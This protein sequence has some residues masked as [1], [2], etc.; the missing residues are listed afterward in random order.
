[1]ALLWSI[2]GFSQI[3]GKQY[4][5]GKL[6]KL[7][8]A[9]EYIKDWESAAEYYNLYLDKKSPDYK[10]LYRLAE[11]QRKGGSYSAAQKNYQT[12][13]EK[14]NDKYPLAGL[15]YAEMLAADGNCKDALPIIKKFRKDYRGEKDDRTYLRLA[16][17]T[18]E[19]CENLDTNAVARYQIKPLSEGVNGSHIEG[20]P[21]YLNN[22]TIVYN[23]L[24]TKGKEV[25][26]VEEDEIPKRKFYVA[27][28]NYGVWEHKSEWRQTELYLQYEIANGA[29]NIAGNRF[30]FS[31]CEANSIGKMA[32]DIY[33]MQQEA[34]EWKPAKKLPAI[35]NSPIYTETQVAVGL[36]EKDQETIY[37]VSDRKEGKGGLDIWYTT[38]D[39]DNDSYKS[40]RNCGSKINSVGDE[41]TPFYKPLNRTLFFS[42]NGHPNYGGLDIFKSSGARTKWLEPENIGNEINTAAD[43][44][45]YVESKKGGEGIFASNRLK[46]GSEDK[47]CCDDLYEFKDVNRIQIAV[48]GAMVDKMKTGSDRYMEGVQ[49]RLFKKDQKTGEEVLVQTVKTKK[50]GKYQFQLEQ[51]QFYTL[52]T[53]KVGFLIQ[54]HDIITTGIEKSRRYIKNFALEYYFGRSIVVENIYYEFDKAALTQES[55]ITIDTTIYEILVENPHIIIELSSHTDS[56]GSDDYN[57]NLSQRRAESVVNYL[58]KKGIPKKRLTPKGYGENKPRVPNKNADGSDN[59]EGRAK[60]RRTEFKVIG[61]MDVEVNY[62]E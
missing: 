3:E 57:E 32:C 24:K 13:F 41:M 33:V 46:P 40:V 34:G 28:K 62:K 59:P 4:S 10:V 11:V 38:Y 30:Y 20:S 42:S 55:E 47:F 25:F 8:K 2:L 61:E 27:E 50:D 6:K 31:A 18:A 5:A 7:A 44:L 19:A 39:E 12:V 58:I 17:F 35:V 36:D 54:E 16:K 43:E 52:K 51:D 49:I 48:S 29:F 45:Y 22:E 21:I 37:F 53:E 15:H 60:N 14:E 26:N 1:M 9:A 23:S 56:E